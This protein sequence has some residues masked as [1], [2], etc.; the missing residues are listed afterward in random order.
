MEFWTTVEDENLKGFEHPNFTLRTITQTVIVDGVKYL[1]TISTFY[2]DTSGN[3]AVSENITRLGNDKIASNDRTSPFV[4]SNNISS[5]P[6]LKG[7]PW[8]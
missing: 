7:S 2:H 1:K 4:K 8:Q 3:M 5:N 6:T